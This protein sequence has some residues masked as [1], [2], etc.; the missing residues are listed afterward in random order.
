MPTPPGTLAVPPLQPATLARLLAAP[1]P[2]PIDPSSGPD[3][4][5][6]RRLAV[7]AAVRA[8]WERAA[9][10][11]DVDAALADKWLD[12]SV[13]ALAAAVARPPRTLP[14][15]RFGGPP[16]DTVPASDL[17]YDVFVE[18]YLA[19]GKPVII[20]GVTCGWRAAEELVDASGAP[21]IAAL[22]AL[23]PSAV[24]PVVDCGDDG[25]G[26]A[27]ERWTVAEYGRYWAATCAGTD[28]RRLY[29]KDAHIVRD[30]PGGEALYS[31]PPWF[32]DDWLNGACDAGVI[33]EAAAC[34]DTPTPP[35]PR[36]DYRF[37]Y[38]GP[39]GTA[40]PLHA[41]VLGSASWSASVAGVKRW[42]LLPPHLTPALYD[43]FGRDLAPDFDVP[44]D[45]PRFPGVAAVAAPAASEIEQPVGSAIFVPPG[46]H[47]TVANATAALSINH[48]WVN[49]AT[50]A[51]TVGQLVKERASAESA[52]DDCR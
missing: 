51:W 15:A 3:P 6:A 42:R 40:T 14:V 38:V 25:R 34:D 22:A 33:G 41:D 37:L 10:G 43:R 1:P 50:A 24:V 23:A 27:R 49:A 11:C 46:W 17:T 35:P 20:T 39:A 21:N 44:V 9:R 12:G 19:P 18:R 2:T 48:N 26:G 29:L 31:V 30:V 52:I 47:H 36:D 5:A 4:A 7:A 45:D 8:A 16:I 32:A 28:S 13:D